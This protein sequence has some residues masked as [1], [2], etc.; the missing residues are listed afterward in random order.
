METVARRT[1]RDMWKNA[2]HEEV[3]AVR[4]R[5]LT[6]RETAVSPGRYSSLWAQPQGELADRDQFM[7]SVA[8]ELDTVGEE[9]L[10]GDGWRSRSCGHRGVETR[11]AD[12]ECASAAPTDTLS[13]QSLTLAVRIRNPNRKSAACASLVEMPN[14]TGDDRKQWRQNDRDVEKE[15]GRKFS[16]P[17]QFSVVRKRRQMTLISDTCLAQ[18]LF[19]TTGTCVR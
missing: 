1:G 19:Q 15:D 3:Q 5:H 12:H 4:Y 14:P 10:P 9:P 11:E 17:C 6:L 8:H 16:F 7:A 18:V 13:L 2:Q